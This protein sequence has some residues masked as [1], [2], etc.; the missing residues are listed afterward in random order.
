[1]FSEDLQWNKGHLLRRDPNNPNRWSVID[2]EL[3]SGFRR[4][5]RSVKFTTA[6]FKTSAALLPTSGA[7]CQI[8]GGY[9][10][11]HCS[12]SGCYKFTEIGGAA[13]LKSSVLEVALCRELNPNIDDPSINCMEQTTHSVLRDDPSC[14]SS[15]PTPTPEVS[16]TPCS[17]GTCEDPSA[18]PVDYCIWNS[19]C[20]GGKQQGGYCCYNACPTS[21]PPACN[22]LLLQ[23]RP[24]W[25]IWTCIP[26]RAD[27]EECDAEG[28]Y[29]NFEA[30]S[31]H[32]YCA[33]GSCPYPREWD[34]GLCR[35]I[36]DS[37]ILI[38]VA[39]NGFDLT[40]A[41]NGVNFDL[42]SDGTA[43]RLAWT[44]SSSDDAWLVLDRNGDGAIDNGRELFGS[45]TSQ[46]APPSGVEENGFNALAE[47]DKRQNSGN[48][49]GV[50]DE[51]DSIFSSLRL[52]QDANHN[53]IS[54]PGELHTLSELSLKTLNLDFKQS[55]RT[56]QYGNQFRYRAMVKDVHDAQV[57]RWA[58]DVILMRSP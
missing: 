23:P 13:G 51:K 44:K 58:W 22:G 6:A 12:A 8:Y 30:L 39:G 17:P 48:G 11:D 49:D 18:I 24:P 46:P 26:R 36:I 31:C 7:K 52:W 4:L 28:W 33:P 19:G 15:S 5:D 53:G 27:E 25:C 35:C 9:F 32:D 43:E 16:P 37:P 38:D 41:T 3:L 42:N 55:K 56:D 29:W 47:Y 34:P 54:E 45:F 20:P 21:T 14:S 1:M 50:I 40:D 2:N 57:D 10:A